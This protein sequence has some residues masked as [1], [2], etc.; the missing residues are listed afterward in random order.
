MSSEPRDSSPRP[1]S[2]PDLRYVRELAKVLRQNDLDEIEIE[3]GEHRVLLRRN[4]GLEA[5]PVAARPVVYEA[6]A[7]VPAAV[8]AAAAPAAPATAPAAGTFITS[9][10]VGTFYRSAGPDTP[11]FVEVGTTVQRNQTLCIVEAMKLF[12]ELEAEFP[13]VIEEILL[14]NAKPVEYGA[15][16]FRVR[17]L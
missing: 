2:L 13:C 8:A 16:L 7:A 3:S 10:F 6:P 15:K 9:P 17:K 14:E 1:D 11:S 4:T 5:A 12:N